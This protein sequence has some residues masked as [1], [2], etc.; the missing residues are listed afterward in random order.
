MWREHRFAVPIKR[1]SPTTI[2]TI[3]FRKCEVAYVPDSNI[4]LLLLLLSITVIIIII[5]IIRQ[6]RSNNCL[7]I[8]IINIRTTI[9]FLYI[10]NYIIPAEYD[11]PDDPLTPTI[12]DQNVKPIILLYSQNVLVRVIMACTLYRTRR[13]NV[14]Q[15]VFYIIGLD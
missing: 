12:L 8:K 15:T 11:L 9:R 10:P 14:L 7:I 6:R 5:D 3:P 13:S 4:I 2:L 1:R